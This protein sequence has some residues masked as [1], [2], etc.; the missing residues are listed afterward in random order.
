MRRIL[1]MTSFAALALFYTRAYCRQANLQYTY[2]PE[3]RA[4]SFENYC[5]QKRNFSLRIGVPDHSAEKLVINNPQKNG[6]AL[7]YLHGFGATRA[8]GEMTVDRLARELGANTYYLRL[9]GHGLNAAAHAAATFDQYLQVAEDAFLHMHL[10]GKRIVLIGTSTGGL[11]ATYLAA[12][13][14][15]RIH[16][17]ILASPLWD[18][19]NKTTRL[20]NFPGGL[21]LGQLVMGKERDA[22]W[23]KDPEKRQHPDYAKY[24]LVQQKFA[25]LV[26]LNNLRR[27]VVTDDTLKRITCP[28]LVLVHYR[29]ETDKDDTIDLAKIRTSLP[30]LG[31]AS[32]G[33][34]RLVEIAD[35]N[36]ILLSEYVR[37]DKELIL[38]Q[39]TAWLAQVR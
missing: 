27:F 10:L 22:R 14:G 21:E 2:S 32:Q 35:G 7:L 19:G 36:H 6:T 24:W 31:S 30:L 18:F 1:L 25:A 23:K 11:I 20:L 34:N 5:A 39:M 15:A 33:K 12:K 17:L 4:D 3:M 38:S 8:E 26:N 16:A 13:Y 37:T 9:P 28:T 29:D